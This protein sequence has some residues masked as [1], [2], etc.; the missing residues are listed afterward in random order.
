MLSGVDRRIDAAIT[1]TVGLHI[2]SQH[3]AAHYGMAAALVTLIV[4]VTLTAEMA[5]QRKSEHI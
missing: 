3:L 5:E 4:S 2:A 1:P